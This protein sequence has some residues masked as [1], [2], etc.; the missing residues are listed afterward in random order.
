MCQPVSAGW[1]A[2]DPAQ[3]A[4]LRLPSGETV[5]LD[6]AAAG[7][8]LSNEPDAKLR[9]EVGLTPLLAI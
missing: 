4:S 5:R 7:Y 3:A 1:N 6:Q 9:K 2:T 8:I